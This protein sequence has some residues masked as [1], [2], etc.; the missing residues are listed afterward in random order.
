MSWELHIQ[1]ITRKPNRIGWASASTGWCRW[2]DGRIDGAIPRR[3]TYAPADIISRLNRTGHGMRRVRAI[4]FDSPNGPLAVCRNPSVADIARPWIDD[5]GGCVHIP[6][7]TRAGGDRVFA[8]Q[9]IPEEVLVPG[10]SL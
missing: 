2:N 9:I 5:V 1:F 3:R 10:N 8:F 4:A 7:I 6:R